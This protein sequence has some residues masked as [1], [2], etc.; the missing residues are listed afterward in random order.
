MLKR[1]AL[2]LF[3]GIAVLSVAAWQ[4]GAIPHGAEYC[5]KND[6]TGHN[7]CATHHVALVALWKG[8]KFFEDHE[9]AITAFFTIVLAGS[10]IL[11]WLA[12]KRLWETTRDTLGHAENTA[13]RQLR[14]YVYVRPTELN[15]TGELGGTIKLKAN[16]RAINGGQT[17]ARRVRIARIIQRLP[18]H[19]PP[20][21]R[22]EEPVIQGPLSMLTLASGP[23]N[24][25]EGTA[26]ATLS[27][28][29]GELESKGER[30]YVVGIVKYF[31]VFDIERVTEF[32]YL[33]TNLGAVAIKLAA[34]SP[35]GAEYEFSDQHNKTT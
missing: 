27:G 26:E 6:E 23:E 31:D 13:E 34:G 15:L 35:I 32:C 19:L 24:F 9:G 1:A 30:I 12:T 10:T 2:A 7:D 22:F 17:P 29:I 33:I 25:F 8:G 3:L 5:E 28:N 4:S 18:Y 21:T 16:F 11:L 20:N 14:A